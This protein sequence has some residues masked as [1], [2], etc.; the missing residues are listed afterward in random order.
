MNDVSV[1]VYRLR[2][3]K[4]TE[5]SHVPDWRIYDDRED[6]ERDLLEA[7]VEAGARARNRDDKVRWLL[8]AYRRALGK[9]D[10]KFGINAVIGAETLT[11]GEW[12][13]MKP[14]LIPPSVVFDV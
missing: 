11:E 5:S 7:L 6:F 3:S 2:L 9:E 1:R 14:R 13:D 10:A 12:V 8:Q 4:G